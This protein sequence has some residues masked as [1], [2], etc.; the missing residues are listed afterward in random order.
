MTVA[1]VRILGRK[2]EVQHVVGEGAYGV[3]MKCKVADQSDKLVA[4]KSFK[5]E[6]NSSAIRLCMQH[7]HRP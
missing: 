5:I 3:V 6:V 1:G 4:I 2:Y 7:Y